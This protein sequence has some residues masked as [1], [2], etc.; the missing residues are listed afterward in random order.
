LA[1]LRRLLLAFAALARASFAL[2][3]PRRTDCDALFAR[4]LESLQPQIAAAGGDL[5]GGSLPVV[6]ADPRQLEHVLRVLIGNALRHRGNEPPHLHVSARP[7]G[8]E[9][10][11][12]V[13]D[14]GMGV[15]PRRHHAIF[16]AF[17]GAGELPGCRRI[18]E[19]HGGRMWVESARGHGATFYFSLPATR[20]VA[21]EE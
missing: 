12:A 13:R 17:S 3:L 2:R 18:V 11:F 5:H 14:N 6:R 9:W 8:R 20:E 16:S 7:A 10:L 21:L 15:D 4:L 19:R 1:E